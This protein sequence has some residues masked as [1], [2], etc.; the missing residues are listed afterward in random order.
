MLGLSFALGV[1]GLVSA[2]GM[3][4]SASYQVNQRLL[5]SEQ[6]TLY[7]SFKDAEENVLGNRREGESAQNVAERISALQYVKQTG[8]ASFVAPADIT[9]TR[10]SPYEEEPHT[11]IGLA[12]PPGANGHAHKP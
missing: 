5:G 3:S 12:C 9:I 6:S 8:F 10:F 4:E 2:S 7:V 1:G 11:A